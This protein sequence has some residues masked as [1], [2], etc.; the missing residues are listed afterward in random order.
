MLFK[1]LLKVLATHCLE[2]S[3][4]RRPREA[5]RDLVRVLSDVATDDAEPVRVRER[6]LVLS[7]FNKHMNFPVVV[8]ELEGL[9]VL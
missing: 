3:E 1:L 5:L 6:R 4:A 2:L 7:A 8:E 9:T